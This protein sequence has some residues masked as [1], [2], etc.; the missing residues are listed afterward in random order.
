[1]IEHTLS[2]IWSDGGGPPLNSF[3]YDSSSQ[4]WGG[5]LTVSA[6]SPDTA[7]AVGAAVAG[8]ASIVIL[9]SQD[10]TL[11]TRDGSDVVDTFSLTAGIPFDWRENTG[12]DCPFT[13]DF[14]S[15]HFANAGGLDARVR[16]WLLCDGT[17]LPVP[18]SPAAY[19]PA[20]YLGGAYCGNY[21]GV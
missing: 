19:T 5:D 14:Q 17:S 6:G 9:V 18:P 15:L 8:L 3:T 2:D 1:M 11:T 10:V 13:G 16:F 20:I 21:F 12:I 4:E 7:A